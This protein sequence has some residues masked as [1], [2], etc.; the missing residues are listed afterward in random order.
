MTA[1][2]RIL[3]PPQSAMNGALISQ[4]SHDVRT[5]VSAILGALQVL[6]QAQLNDQQT[7]IAAAGKRA[8]MGLMGILDNFIE[9]VRLDA[10]AV[11]L[12]PE[13]HP[14]AALKS[15][16]TRL[17]ADAMQGGGHDR[18]C[19]TLSLD[20]DL[21][22]NITMD[23]FY[24]NLILANLIGN[25]VA[26][27]GAQG[28]HLSAARADGDDV[29]ITVSDCG[30]GIPDARVPSLFAPRPD[31]DAKWGLGLPMSAAIARL[32]GCGLAL[33][34]TGPQGSAFTLHIPA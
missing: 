9:T 4:V 21:P 27:A 10:D 6:S 20:D 25:A 29:R 8:A 34:A 28:V 12:R 11:I 1:C 7:A 5:P 19:G 23:S 32:M 33:K 18:T 3:D 24:V 26:H 31:T 14:L 17:L 15:G 2:D 16:W 22:D 13:P 30:P